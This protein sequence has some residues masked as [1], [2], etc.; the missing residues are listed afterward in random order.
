MIIPQMAPWFDSNEADAIAGY[1]A[2]SC[3]LTEYHK[4]T[5]LEIMIADYVGS[6]HCIMVPNGTLALYAALM[7]LGIGV[8]DRVLVPDLTMIATVNAVCMT[9]ARPV[10][11]DISEDNLCFDINAVSSFH[12]D[13]N[14][15]G[16]I[17]VSLNGRAPNMKDTQV[18]ARDHDIFL[19]ED[20]C[21]ALG[22]FQSGRHLGTFGVCGIFSFSPHKIVTT[23]QGGC[24]VT[25]DDSLAHKIRLFKNFGRISGGNDDYQEFGVN[26]RFTDLQAVIGIEQMK[27]LDWRVSRKKRMFG[28]YQDLLR[29]IKEVHFVRT[30]LKDTTPWFIDIFVSDREKLSDFLTECGIGSR[31][32]YP[33]IRRTPVY[34]DGAYIAT[35]WV[36][37][38]ISA[39][40][41]WLPSSP[42]LTDQQIHEV[43]DA[44]VEYYR[45]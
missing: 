3:W 44:V 39:Q 18:W 8:G 22:S 12:Y 33:S 36:S 45:S 6:R 1:L 2:S 27:K 11:I 14:L 16:A 7:S 20:A 30:D 42:A 29:D 24:I 10:F 15:R 25:D 5:E 35:E 34:S 21:Q 43:C 38:R 13:L 28:L 40:G 32:M 4:T 31:F 19:I 37:D 23:G 17:I 26:L 9:G 41:L